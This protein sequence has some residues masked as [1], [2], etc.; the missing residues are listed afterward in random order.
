MGYEFFAD[1][2]NLNLMTEAEVRAIM[3]THQGWSFRF[4]PTRLLG[5]PSNIVL[6]A[7]RDKL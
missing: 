5:W 4:A 7:H 3:E 6:M 2:A 1:E